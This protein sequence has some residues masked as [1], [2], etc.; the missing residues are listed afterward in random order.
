MARTTGTDNKSAAIRE[1]KRAHPKSKPRQIAAA[2]AEKG[3]KMSAQYVSV[4]LSNARKKKGSRSRTA[5]AGG[6]AVVVRGR[7]R[8]RLP[9]NTASVAG[10]GLPELRLAKQLLTTA[11]GA[12]QARQAIDTMAAL[13]G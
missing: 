8:P 11:G 6:E 1:Y 4:V 10:V 13:L 9:E 7:G 12:K 2:L 5:A 3:H